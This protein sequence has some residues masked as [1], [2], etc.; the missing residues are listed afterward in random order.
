MRRAARVQCNAATHRQE[1]QNNPR[2]RGRGRHECL[3]R[4]SF[5]NAIAIVLQLPLTLN[6]RAYMPAYRGRGASLARRGRC[7]TSR[8]RRP[9]L[10]YR[11]MNRDRASGQRRTARLLGGREKPRLVLRMQLEARASV[12]VR[13]EVLRGLRGA[14]APRGI[15]RRKHRRNAEGWT[16]CHGV[17]PSRM[18]SA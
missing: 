14:G 5:E 11:R 4:T 18:R 9:G 10:E 15:G 2:R 17:K 3:P 13:L 12:A 7:P 6:E 16:T 8:W 1:E